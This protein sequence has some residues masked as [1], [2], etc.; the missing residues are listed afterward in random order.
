MKR[1]LMAMAVLGFLLGGVA[2]AAVQRGD[3]ELDFLGSYVQENGADYV[4][5]FESWSV[6]GSFGYFLTDNIRV[7]VGAMWT[8]MDGTDAVLF[9][10]QG[11]DVWGVGGSIKYHFMPTNQWV[12]YVGAQILWGRYESDGA[13]DALDVGKDGVLWGPLAGVRLELNANNDFFIEYQYHRWDGNFRT[14]FEDGHAVFLGIA[15]QFK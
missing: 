5:D 10:T 7:G 13:L 2:T 8:S 14:V 15:H 11:I 4:S 12:P 9:G 6:A 3:T 1:G